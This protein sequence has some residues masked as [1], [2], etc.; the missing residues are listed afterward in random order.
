MVF[1][2]SNAL[3]VTQSCQSTNP[4][5]LQ[6]THRLHC[7][8]IYHRV[9]RK[10][11]PI[12]S[13]LQCQQLQLKLTYN[14]LARYGTDGRLFTT[15][16]SA[17]FKVTWHK[18][19]DNYKKIR[20]NQIYVLCPSLR[21]RGQLPAPIVNGGKDSFWKWKDFQLSRACDLDRGS[22]HTA[23]CT[24]RPILTCQISLKSKKLFVANRTYGVWMERHLKM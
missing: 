13:A 7:F 8:I 1:Y 14:K 4:K 11:A 19:W 12:M 5:P 10:G 20:P 21:I 23:Y 9:L 18:N 6:I 16:I 17:T 15:G 24:Q 2:R 22:G 3:L